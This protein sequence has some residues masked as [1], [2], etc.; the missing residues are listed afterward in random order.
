MRHHSVLAWEAR[1]DS[2]MREI[3]HILEEKYHGDYTLHPAR[4]QRGKTSNPSQDGL[5]SI[6]ANFSLGLGSEVGKGYIVDIRLVTLQHVPEA[7]R[8]EIEDFVQDK[9]R[10]LLPQEF[11]ESE[12]S[13]D[14]DGP[15]LKI[16]GDLSLG[17]V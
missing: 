6:A 13:V 17:K 9:L 15:V 11:P 14:K 4:A 10:E 16:H 1:L 5:F 2:I 3:D 7:V 12:L 8:D